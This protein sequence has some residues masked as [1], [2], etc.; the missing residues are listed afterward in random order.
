[1]EKA[2]KWEDFTTEEKITLLNHWFYYYGGVVLTLKD[3]EL[4][5]KL[6]ATRPDDIFDHI[7][8]RYIYQST[9]KTNLL[10]SCLRDETVDE[11]LK[12]SIRRE[13]VA[14]PYI[15]KYEDT[16]R[17]ISEEI[18]NTFI[19]PEPAVQMDIAILVKSK[20]PEDNQKEL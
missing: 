11:L 15:E 2:K 12:S 3:F 1:M 6:T 19:N 20:K 17:L 4:F 14:D 16:R 9:I 13:F 18:F 8:T 5:R 7:V 10:V